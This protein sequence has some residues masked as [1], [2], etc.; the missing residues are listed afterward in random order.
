M[1]ENSSLK[2]KTL[3][4]LFWSSIE[5][6]SLQ[7]VQFII[8]IIM[9]RLLL[10]ADYGLV[11]MLAIFLSISQV[12]IDGG[13]G[14]ALIQKKD[15]SIQDYSTAFL[16]NVYIALFFYLLLFVTAPYIACFY[17]APQ[18]VLVTRIIALSLLLNSCYAVCRTKLTI[19]VNFKTISKSSLIAA[20]LSGTIGIIMAYHG[21]GVWSIVG[22]TLLN[23]IFSLGLFYYFSK[24][25]VIFI[26]SK[27]SFKNMWNF[28]FKLMISNLIHNI[29]IN[30]YSVVI[31]RYFSASQLGYYTRAEQFASF[32]ASNFSM[33][34]SRV[35]F[36]ILSELQD[37]NAKLKR[38]YEK[39]LRISTC[40]IFPL[41]VGLIVLAS[42]LISVIL[43]DRWS[44]VTILL[45][46]LAFAWMFD[47]ISAI[48][49]GVLYVKGRSDVVLRLEYVKKTTA[50]IILL[51]SISFGLVGMCIGRAL[52]SI[53][54]IFFNSYYSKPI[55]NFGIFEQLKFICLYFFYAST[56]G[57]IIFLVN[58]FIYL[59]VLKLFVGLI[60]GIF[61]YV[62]LLY[63]SKDVTLKELKGG[64][65]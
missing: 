11:G 27:V 10:P 26:F 8:N 31:G 6:F 58:S 44:E 50:I 36:P 20:A 28:G 42:P 5:R 40:I 45:Q 15:R 55:L 47:H 59:P 23:S 12:F 35:M 4:G 17:N 49:L 51:I 3:R 29:Y 48:N 53:I 43:T 2:V 22:Q 9:A 7:G 19:E 1:E 21:F 61:V 62:T 37:D 63:I 24:W 46:I 18:L 34:I 52:Y 41:M 56:M 32:P 25:K 16:C 13:F 38:V 54:A 30:M 39:Y 65:K 14:D 64:F 60:I 33:I 57:F